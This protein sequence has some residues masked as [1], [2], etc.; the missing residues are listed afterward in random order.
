MEQTADNGPQN[1]F[2][3]NSKSLF[4][5]RSTRKQAQESALADD[6]ELV[7]LAV[8]SFIALTDTTKKALIKKTRFLEF[9]MPHLIFTNL[10]IIKNTVKYEAFLKK[11]EEQ[12]ETFVSI[13]LSITC[14]K[15][16]KFY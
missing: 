6:D 2:L 16:Y 10:Q 1:I 3:R 13:S 11:K 14:L 9:F 15:C 5:P 4:I 8:F 7:E 12:E